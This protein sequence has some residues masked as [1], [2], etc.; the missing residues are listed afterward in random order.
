MGAT[1]T[2]QIF[3]FSLAGGLASLLLMT[4]WIM[5]SENFNL[6][7]LPIALAVAY[8]C[9]I[10]VTMWYEQ[11]Y[12]NLWDIA[13]HTNYWFEYYARPFKLLEV[14]TDM[15]LVFVAYPW[16]RRSNIKLVIL[17]SALSIASFGAWFETG[18]VFPTTSALAY[19]LNASSRI[20][21]QLAMAVSVFKRYQLKQSTAP[22]PNLASVPASPP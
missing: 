14:V 19:F 7:S 3:A 15:G 1:G 11:L 6:K 21:S 10:A 20:S 9:T 22:I 4:Y 5:K 2:S 16:M 13:N 12:A 17:F 8:I 18:F